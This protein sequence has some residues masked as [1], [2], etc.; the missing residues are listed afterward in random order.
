MTERNKKN[1]QK[2]LNKR[3]PFQYGF[4]FYIGGVFLLFVGLMML[5]FTAGWLSIKHHSPVFFIGIGLFGLI[6]VAIYRE[7]FDKP[8]PDPKLEEI[9]ATREQIIDTIIKRAKRYAVLVGVIALV[10]VAGYIQVTFGPQ[11]TKIEAAEEHLKEIQEQKTEIDSVRKDMDRLHQ[12]AGNLQ[13][14]LTAQHDYIEQRILVFDSSFAALAALLPQA[15]TAVKEL[16]EISEH[17]K[18]IDRDF[19][20]FRDN[21]LYE[22]TI[23]YSSR[24]APIADK[25]HSMLGKRGFQVYI[26]EIKESEMGPFA[27]FEGTLFYYISEDESKAGSIERLLEGQ[28]I[29]IRLEKISDSQK[30]KKYDVWP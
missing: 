22:V 8:V 25:V 15:R 29:N 9:I 1:S 2:S 3:H 12:E 30:A 14:F 17:G 28:G 23:H 16:K 13:R 10:G 26:D 20:E 4:W 6:V 24:R 21:Q 7:M 11:L 18:I 27:G 19:S 5:P